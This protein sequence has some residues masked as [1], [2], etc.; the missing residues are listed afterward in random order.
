[1][2]DFIKMFVASLAALL[3]VFAMLL[4]M[5]GIASLAERPP[6]V[7]KGSFLVID[8]YGEIPPYYPP[9][10]IMTQIFGGEPETLQ[11]ILTNLEK[12]A[13]D[14]RIAGVIVKV[15][16]NNSLGGASMEEIR[17][18]IKNVRAAGKKV[19]AF[20]DSMNRGSLFLAS[21]CDSIFMPVSSDLT[22]IGMGGTQL[23]I[24]GLLDKLLL[25]LSP[26]GTR[27]QVSEWRTG[28][29]HIA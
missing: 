12:A 25:G 9:G 2:K 1:M 6:E 7:K 23:Y 22:F 26:E 20:S 21:A 4:G 16:S 8:I 10:D 13:V 27:R 3:F 18:A 19:Y 29:Y 24:K 11:R 5:A 14:D 17:D 15:S 28:F